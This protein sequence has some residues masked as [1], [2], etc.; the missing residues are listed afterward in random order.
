[1]RKPGRWWS[2]VW[3][4][5][6]S[7]VTRSFSSRMVDSMD[8]RRLAYS[9]FRR[10]QRRNVIPAFW[11]TGSP[12]AAHRGTPTRGPTGPAR[13]PAKTGR[14]STSHGCTDSRAMTRI[15]PGHP[16]FRT[17]AHW[18]LVQAQVGPGA[19]GGDFATAAV[20]VQPFADLLHTQG[21]A[22]DDSIGAAMLREVNLMESL[23]IVAGQS[24]S[25]LRTVSPM[26]SMNSTGSNIRSPTSST[27]GS[28][29]CRRR[30]P[31]IAFRRAAVRSTWPSTCR[32]PA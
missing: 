22:G 8:H 15:A 7:R 23:A 14:G 20:E 9:A 1:M 28:E 2:R 10:R 19:A 27:P 24:V 4:T 25:G 6:G 26:R 32:R 17:Q 5:S 13:S 12:V 11:A 31:P 29:R 16:P 18:Y 30:G 3:R 21:L